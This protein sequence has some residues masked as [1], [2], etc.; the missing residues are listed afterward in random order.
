MRA[1]K[2]VQLNV[3]V[4]PM[5]FPKMGFKGLLP[6]WMGDGV[7]KCMQNEVHWDFINP[8]GDGLYVPMMWYD[9]YYEQS[10]KVKDDVNQVYFA[11]KLAKHVKLYGILVAVVLLVCAVTCFI[12]AALRRTRERRSLPPFEEQLLMQ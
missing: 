2:R 6:G 3:K 9:E 4:Q 12:V 11:N 5:S 10:N 7:L 1:H 8:M